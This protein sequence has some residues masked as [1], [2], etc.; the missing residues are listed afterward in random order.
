M[1]WETLYKQ[2]PVYQTS[3]SLNSTTLPTQDIIQQHSC[4]ETM[5]CVTVHL[6]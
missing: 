6:C 1:K 5:D 2:K 4:Y 3:V